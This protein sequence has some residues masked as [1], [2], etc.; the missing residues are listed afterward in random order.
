MD[1]YVVIGN[2]V[3]HSVS[4]V[5]HARFAA[6]TGE[7]LEYGRMLVAPGEFAARAREFFAGGGSGANVTLPFKIDA[8]EFA[9][10]R[11]DRASAAGAANFLVLR[12]GRIH[13]DNTDGAGL[14]NDLARNL[15]CEI[16][17][18]RIL[19]V[20]AGGAARGVL[21]PLLAEM[22]AELVIANRTVA[23]AQE[24]RD[25]FA[26]PGRVE[27]C[28]LDDLPARPFDVIVNATSSSTLGEALPLP[29]ALFGP[30]TL[31]YDMAYGRAAEAFLADARSRGARASDGLGMLVEQA[32]ESFLLWRGKR[33]ETAPV[34]AELR[35]R[36]G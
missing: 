13:A 4:P 35:A 16:R 20:G 14:V 31:A 32:A 17:G 9:D 36:A 7:R 28:G 18:A 6:Q 33:P 1:R 8:F 25:R 26:S 24:L 27:A 10:L 19:L 34:I 5:I 30:R 11:S 21:A 15:G 23:R 22:P 29:H 3:A 12:G 2:P